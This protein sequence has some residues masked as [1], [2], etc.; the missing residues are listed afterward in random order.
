VEYLARAAKPLDHPKT[1]AVAD[2]AGMAFYYLL[3]VGEYT[4]H[5]EKQQ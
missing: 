4:Y 3:R 5:N 2:L 1:Q